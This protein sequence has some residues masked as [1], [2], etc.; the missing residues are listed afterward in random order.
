MGGK[1]KELYLSARSAQ[2]QPG[3]NPPEKLYIS[4]R[5]TRFIEKCKKTGVD[6][7]IL[8]ALYGFVFPE[9]KKKDYNVTMR[10]DKNCWLDIAVIRDQ[11]KLSRKESKQHIAKLTSARAETTSK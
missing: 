2:K 5:I 10:T 8:S 4:D 11:Q 3:V 9:E 1:M 6:W 7:A